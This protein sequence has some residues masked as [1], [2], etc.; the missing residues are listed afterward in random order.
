LASPA[1]SDSPCCRHLGRNALLL[2]LYQLHRMESPAATSPR[3]S[4]CSPLSGSAASDHS[5]A[6]P[7]RWSLLSM[8]R[9]LKCLRFSCARRWKRQVWCSRCISVKSSLGCAWSAA[10]ALPRH[11]GQVCTWAPGECVPP[12]L[13]LPFLSGHVL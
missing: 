10:R 5:D 6:V 3:R 2:A 11:A 4:G 8:L 13:P 12:L 9:T 1:N 7:R